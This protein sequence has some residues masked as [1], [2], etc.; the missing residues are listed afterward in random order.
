[1]ELLKRFC[2]A[3]GVSGR[4]D[5]LVELF[6]EELKNTADEIWT[7]AIKNVTAVKYGTDGDNRPK[8]MIAGHIDEI[9]F[10]IYNIDKD[11]FASIVPVGGWSAA[12]IFGHTVR[13]HTRKGEILTG[14]VCAPPALTPETASKAMK[15]DKLFIDFGMTA[16][17]VKKKVARGDWVS[18]DT[19]FQ[20]MGDCF[21]A[22]AFDD[23]V[24][25][26]IIAEAFRKYSNP[27]IDV[28]CVGTSQEE[29]GLR[30]STVAAQ[31][32]Q[33]DIGIAAD[34]T[35]A[36][37][38]PGFPAAMR[39]CDLGKGVAIKQQDAS[40]IC[41][42]SLV[43]FIRDIAEEKEIDHQMEILVRGGTDTSSMQKFGGN[44]HATCLSIPTRNGHSPVAIIHRHDVETAVEL[45]V[46]F[47]NRAH[48]F[49]G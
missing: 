5:A 31:A 7:D 16:E 4:E 15:L 32:I 9:G 27:N 14:V 30:G 40:V 44:T 17:T 34:I 18:M 22:K 46:E 23:R 28:Y 6:K 26:Y 3:D 35:G 25:V 36:G 12:S 8:V 20:E 39:I 41:S 19:S 29:V 42:P 49:N 10:L 45:L 1:M 11:G 2:E 13:V 38:T 47:L 21:V 43:N 37:D 24:G 33:P 48:L